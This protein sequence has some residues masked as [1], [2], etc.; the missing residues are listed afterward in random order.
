MST[1]DIEGGVTARALLGH[2]LA[3]EPTG[4]GSLG[5]DLVWHDGPGGS[6]LATVQG[7]DNLAQD[8]TVALLTP[9]GT[10]PFNVG[11]GFDGLRVL[12]LDT[13][14]ALT[15]ELIRLAVIRTL[16][17]D[18]R[19]SEVLDVTLEPAGPDR[20]QR[21]TAQARTVLGDALQLTLGEV[22]F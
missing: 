21:V 7:V 9:T 5:L 1:P 17:A 6:V 15:Q 14:P 2:G 3:L 20:R 12:T 22:E 16:T 19:I 8:L 10:D 4:P 18:S 11:F 13:P